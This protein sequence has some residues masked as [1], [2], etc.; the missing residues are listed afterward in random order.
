MNKKGRPSHSLLDM[1]AYLCVLAIMINEPL[2]EHGEGFDS[3]MPTASM[4]TQIAS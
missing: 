1:F 4:P 2:S 3:I